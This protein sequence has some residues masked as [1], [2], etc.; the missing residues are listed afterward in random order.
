MDKLVGAFNCMQVHY[1]VEGSYHLIIPL[2]GKG[3]GELN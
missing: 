3:G 2:T 1:L